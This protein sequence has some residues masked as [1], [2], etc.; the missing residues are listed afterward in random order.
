MVCREN[1]SHA[2]TYCRYKRCDPTTSTMIDA[3]SWVER[4]HR[5]RLVWQDVNTVSPSC[6]IHAEPF[7]H[8]HFHFGILREIR[9]LS[10]GSD[11]AYSF[12]NP[13]CLLT[14]SR[15]VREMV[16]E[17]KEKGL[18]GTGSPK[19]L[20]AFRG[21]GPAAQD[22]LV[23][24]MSVPRYNKVGRANAEPPLLDCLKAN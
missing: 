23:L 15:P 19:M 20:P 1:Y 6:R 7:R 4:T 9:L 18:P 12:G 14:H 17:I 22:Q 3:G 10:S 5:A 24:A 2:T 21:W 11:R 8:T 13:L 16:P